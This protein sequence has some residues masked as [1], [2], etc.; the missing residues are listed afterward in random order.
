VDPTQV[1][2][3]DF[4]RITERREALKALSENTDGAAAV[5][6]NDMRQALRPIMDQLRTFYLL[7]YYSTNTK[8]D[9]Q[10]RT[11]SVSSPQ[12]GVEVRARRSYRAPTEEE[13]ALRANPVAAPA[14]TEL[15]RALDVLAGIRSADDRSFNA[16][17]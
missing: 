3:E 2:S 17:R 14:L 8:F 13:R 10:I 4:D 16:A 11:I 1:V 9:G 7:G 15:D 6:T 12:A 5:N